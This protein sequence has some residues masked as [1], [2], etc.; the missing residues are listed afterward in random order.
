MRD[1]Q[2]TLRNFIVENFLFG[3]PDPALTNEAHLFETGIL[4]STGVLEMV[5]FIEERF[6]MTVDDAELVQENFGSINALAEFIS[7]KTQEACHA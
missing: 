7:R 5:A 4:N 3:Q 1:I 6:G 2:E